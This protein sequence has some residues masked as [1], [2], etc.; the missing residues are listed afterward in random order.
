MED[1]EQKLQCLMEEKD[2]ERKALE[3]EMRKAKE[4]GESN[5][6]V[7]EVELSRDLILVSFVNPKP[8]TLNPKLTTL[9]HEP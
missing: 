6:G 5:A 8:S 2:K 4:D 1:M 7:L 9:S 3:D